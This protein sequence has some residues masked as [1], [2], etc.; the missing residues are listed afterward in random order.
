LLR[1]YEFWQF[2]H[3]LRV[4]K[5]KFE[6]K[7]QY[8]PAAEQWKHDYIET[9]EKATSLLE[10]LPSASH[11]ADLLLESYGDGNQMSPLSTTVASSKQDMLSL[12][13]V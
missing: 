6:R 10:K 13:S 3:K 11:S 5:A 12:W 9:E 2:Y 4:E 7:C 8:L 1:D